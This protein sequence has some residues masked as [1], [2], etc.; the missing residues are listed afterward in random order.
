MQDIEEDKAPPRDLN[1]RIVKF[2]TQYK[3]DSKTGQYVVDSRGQMI[4]V[5]Y[6][7]YAMAGNAKYTV[8]HERIIDI[9]RSLV[10]GLWDKIG[11]KYDQW[12]R[13]NSFENDG[14]PLEVW[15][16][17]SEEIMQVLKAHDVKSLEDLRDIS[18]GQI[19]SIGLPGLR[20][21][22]ENVRVFFDTKDQRKADAAINAV[23]EENEDLRRELEEIKA[24]MRGKP[25]QVSETDADAYD[26]A[27]PI[28]EPIMRR[29][30]RPRK[31]KQEME[32][33][34]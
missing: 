19:K 12:K 17:L 3:R 8:N 31:I 10:P 1:I 26:M 20:A 18:D 13:T 23:R 5:D 34:G 21:M 25:P 24:M 16:R 28:D 22:K 29:P 2:S 14:T 32:H 7:D 33:H 27:D 30:G 11:P 4:G 9:E 15:G 6:C